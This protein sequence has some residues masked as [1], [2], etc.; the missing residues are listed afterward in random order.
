MCVIQLISVIP[1]ANEQLRVLCIDQQIREKTATERETSSQGAKIHDNSVT[2][3]Q[4]TEPFFPLCVCVCV[5][6]CMS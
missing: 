2:I 1:L 3:D 5:C 6:V 4:N